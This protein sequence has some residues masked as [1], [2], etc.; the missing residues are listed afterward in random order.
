M[1]D[2][3]PGN[4]DV[5]S[6][7]NILITYFSVT[8]T[9]G[10]DAISR[11]S[12]VV[13][14]GEVVGTTQFVAE[15][16]QEETGGDLFRIETVQE[17]PD[18]HDELVDFAGN[19]TTEGASPELCNQIENL[20]S[21]DT[22]FIGYSV[23]VGDVPMPLYTFLESMDFSDKTVFSFSTHGGS[24]GSGTMDTLEELQPD[25]TFI[26]NGLTISRDDVPESREDVVQWLNSLSLG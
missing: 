13:D 14:N 11:A 18:D 21:Y 23:W 7:S 24:G 1:N 3:T 2:S 12:S 15:T 4:N 22:V 8:E 17:Y 20:D 26:N 16:T 25:V 5:Q 6:D 10:V 9:T 19:K